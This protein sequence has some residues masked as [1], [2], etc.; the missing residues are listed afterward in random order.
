MLLLTLLASLFI[1]LALGFFVLVAAPHRIVNRT[2][3]AFI[4][5]MILWIAKDISFWC[6]HHH[7][8]DA[9]MGDVKLSDWHHLADR[10]FVVC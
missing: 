5:M 3:A 2:F 10:L 8:Q 1:T 7:T 4:G 9:T 6:F